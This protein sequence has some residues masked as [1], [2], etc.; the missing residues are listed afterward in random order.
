MTDKIIINIGITMVVL[1]ILFLILRLFGI[2]LSYSSFG[3]LTLLFG[4]TL[5]RIVEENKQK[6]LKLVITVYV[7]GIISL[8]LIR[9]W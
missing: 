1:G 7:L 3:G 8:L 6:D 5:I 2:F 9:A 4:G